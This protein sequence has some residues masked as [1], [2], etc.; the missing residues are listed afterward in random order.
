MDLKI[1]N[2]IE[3]FGIKKMNSIFISS[4]KKTILQVLENLILE[5]LEFVKKKWD[6]GNKRMD[7]RVYYFRLNVLKTIFSLVVYLMQKRT[8]QLVR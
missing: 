3:I 2:D 4:I 1:K 7:K 5:V 8:I 6:L